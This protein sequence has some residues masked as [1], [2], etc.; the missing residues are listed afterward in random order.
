MIVRVK[1][2]TNFDAKKVLN[3]AK[4]GSIKSLGHA[5]AAIRLVARRSIKTSKKES[6]P[7][8]PPNSRKGQL[9]RAIVYAVENQQ[10]RVVIGPYVNVVGTSGA[11]HEF[12]GKYKKQRYDKRPFMGPALDKVKDRLPQEWAGS[13]K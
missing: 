9:R 6:A 8:T 11:A 7:G 5:G 10:Q 3:A 1:G 4:N 13:V 2:K 12:G